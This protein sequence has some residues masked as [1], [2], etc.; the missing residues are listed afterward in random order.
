MLNTTNEIKAGQWGSSSRISPFD[1]DTQ[2]EIGDLSRGYEW[3]SMG[4]YKGH[5]WKV[6][7][8]IGEKVWIKCLF[9]EV[10]RVSPHCEAW[11]FLLSSGTPKAPGA[12][13]CCCHC[14]AAPLSF[15]G[16]SS[17]PLAPVLPKTERPPGR[18]HSWSK[19][20]LTVK[21]LENLYRWI[22]LLLWTLGSALCCTEVISVC[23]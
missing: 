7:Q 9:I 1:R 12:E 6:N 16:A 15:H 20:W 17:R 18:L 13:M 8:F 22:D 21:Q 19:A 10:I 5:V 11:P 2:L 4:S 3:G 23:E 14:S